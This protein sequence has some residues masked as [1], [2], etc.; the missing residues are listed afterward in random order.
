MNLFDALVDE[1]LRGNGRLSALR[2]VV[3]K[4]IL[5]HDILREMAAAG[6]LRDLTFI[7]GT[8]LRDCYGS[9]RLSEDLDFTG[10]AAFERSAL[11][12]LARHLEVALLKKYGL[13]VT[14]SEPVRETGN[15]DTWKLKMITRP[16]SPHLP[17][18]RVNIDI[19]AID[20]HDPRPAMLK[21]HYRV[22][23]G[24]SGLILNAESREEIL[25][26]KIVALA[27]RPNR[28]KN[29]DLWDIIWLTGQNVSVEYDLVKQKTTDRHIGLTEFSRLLAERVNSLVPLFDDFS[30]ELRRFLP[31]NEYAQVTGQPEYWKYLCSL[32]GEICDKVTRIAGFSGKEQP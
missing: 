27:L 30:F 20:S 24:T 25:A 26:D 12:S 10:G 14:V 4:E 31:A 29:R 11:E 15:V 6:F 18:Q 17:A 3:E 28:V 32:L 8:C 7:G 16:E 21:N 23:L 19:C 22:D 1:A 9:P 2:P 5:H 13:T